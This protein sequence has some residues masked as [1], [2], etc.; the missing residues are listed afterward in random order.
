[1]CA[2]SR[3]LGSH[4]GIPPTAMAWPWLIGFILFFIQ[5][6]QEKVPYS[7]YFNMPENETHFG[8]DNLFC[9]QVGE[10]SETKIKASLF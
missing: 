1:M 4:L 6:E 9:G 7:N 3:D 8:A 2:W 5:K 10:I